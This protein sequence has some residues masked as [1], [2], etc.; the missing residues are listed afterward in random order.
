MKPFRPELSTKTQLYSLSHKKHFNLVSLSYKYLQLIIRVMTFIIH[1][2]LPLL[3]HCFHVVDSQF[4]SS[5]P[6]TGNRSFSSA[7][8]SVCSS[9]PER[10]ILGWQTW[11]QSR[12]SAAVPGRASG[13]RLRPW[14]VSH[15]CT[16]PCCAAPVRSRARLCADISAFHLCTAPLLTH[17]G[18]RWVNKEVFFL[19]VF[20]K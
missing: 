4:L 7:T 18:S 10:G 1:L 14:C 20:F 12:S 5:L 9:S 15:P 13:W 16:L 11:R 3:S 6:L 8:D 19:F 17:R 2:L